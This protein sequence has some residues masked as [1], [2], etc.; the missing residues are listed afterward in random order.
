MEET[1]ADRLRI[2]LGLG[3]VASGSWTFKLAYTAQKARNTTGVDFET[4]DH[5][6]RFSVITTVKI[7]DLIWTQ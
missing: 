5:I 2:T 7:K 1:F 3:Y 4:T 6:L